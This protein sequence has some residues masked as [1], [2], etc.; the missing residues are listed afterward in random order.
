V[1]VP[2]LAVDLRPLGSEGGELLGLGKGAESVPELVE[3]G[4][5][6]LDVQQLELGESIG[7]QRGLLVW[8]LR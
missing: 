2:V 8:C 4:V 5:E 3:P 7:L 1:R 6:L